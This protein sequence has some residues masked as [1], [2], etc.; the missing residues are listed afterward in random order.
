M[1]NVR[2]FSTG[3]DIVGQHLNTHASYSGQVVVVNLGETTR[4][5]QERQWFNDDWAAVW[6]VDPVGIHVEANRTIE[7]S[8]RTV[9]AIR[10]EGETQREVECRVTI[11]SSP[12]WGKVKID[13][14]ALG[15]TVA[16]LLAELLNGLGAVAFATRWGCPSRGLL[17]TREP[18]DLTAGAD[19]L[20]A[21]YRDDLRFETTCYRMVEMT[22]IKLAFSPHGPEPV[23]FFTVPTD[24]VD[25]AFAIAY[26]DSAADYGLTNSVFLPRG[27]I[28]SRVNTIPS[29]E[30]GHILLNTVDDVGERTI[31]DTTSYFS[32]VSPSQR[33]RAILESGPTSRA[34]QLLELASAAAAVSSSVDPQ[35][36]LMAA[37]RPNAEWI[38]LLD[39]FRDVIAGRRPLA[40][41]ARAIARSP[42]NEIMKFAALRA[43]AEA[44]EF[45]FF[46]YEEFDLR[47][48]LLAIG[49]LEAEWVDPIFVKHEHQRALGKRGVEDAFQ[50]RSR[51]LALRNAWS[52]QA[53]DPGL[54]TS[55]ER[56]LWMGYDMHRNG[57]SFWDPARG[58]SPS[59]VWAYRVWSSLPDRRREALIASLESRPLRYREFLHAPRLARVG[60]HLW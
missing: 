15:E 47:L 53:D 23:E 10:F 20:L 5:D 42:A 60:S 55:L 14:G 40:S 6:G 17:V 25:G 27:L 38:D 39:R 9:F 28:E 57:V 11:R 3:P 19:P 12:K 36:T 50:A 26:P 32:V 21:I 13:Q 34:P 29:H 2:R 16:S 58:G 56:E 48:G 1:R 46:R 52:T 8:T 35:R 54:L 43:L 33:A 4:Q 49:G 45:D 7:G 59:V 24:T 22:A 37:R 44:A 31:M 41:E 30:I 51:A 18:V